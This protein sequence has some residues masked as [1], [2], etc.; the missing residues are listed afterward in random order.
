M[1]VVHACA[2]RAC[3][4]EIYLLFDKERRGFARRSGTWQVPVQHVVWVCLPE[5]QDDQS[6]ITRMGSADIMGSRCGVE[7]TDPWEEVQGLFEMYLI[8]MMKL[9]KGGFEDMTGIYFPRKKKPSGKRFL[10]TAL[11]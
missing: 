4:G 11:P 9:S 1:N 3:S 10:M 2:F 6:G 7:G 5:A 8:D